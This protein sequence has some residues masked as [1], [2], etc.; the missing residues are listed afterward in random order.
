[1]RH[2]IFSGLSHGIALYLSKPKFLLWCIGFNL[3]FSA[4]K[5][6]PRLADNNFDYV[7]DPTVSV[8]VEGR[9]VQKTES[10][11][12]LYARIQARKA[13]IANEPEALLSKY[14]LTIEVR[15]DYESDF[16]QWADTIKTRHIKRLPDGKF[17]LAY[18]FPKPTID[19]GIVLLKITDLGNNNFAWFD[20]KTDFSGNEPHHRF[21]LADNNNNIWLPPFCRDRDTIT[22]HNTFIK[23]KEIHVSHYGELFP[24]ALPIMAVNAP[25]PTF[26]EITRVFKIEEGQPFIF[27]A[28]GLYLFKEDS[29]ATSGFSVLVMPNKY[30][31]VAQPR[32]LSGPLVYMTTREEKKRINS[33]TKPKETLDQFWLE[34]GGSKE[35]ARRVLREFY[36][37]VE[38][39]NRYFSTFKEGWRSDQGMVYTI[40][41]KPERVTRTIEQEEWYYQ[42]QGNLPEFKFVFINRPTIFGPYN[43]ELQR[44]PEYA[45]IWYTTVEQWR[46][47]ILKK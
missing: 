10:D 22:V 41:G 9:V 25:K 42:R 21:F 15:Q 34:L 46:K 44:A 26:P 1:M 20:F 16:I 8:K 37:H 11:Y 6:L 5:T 7:Y 40:F 18:Q 47:G 2:F 24:P 39:A 23:G 38:F 36:E 32:D 33:S 28:P 4:C 43:L 30:P 14:F 27:L 19:K 3:L 12:A 13:T 35:N 17:L 29:L 45:D 31:R